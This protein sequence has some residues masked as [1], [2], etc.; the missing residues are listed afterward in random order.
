[1]ELTPSG[2]IGNP[3]GG[4][5][6]FMAQYSFA[7]DVL[8]DHRESVLNYRVNSQSSPC[9]IY[10]FSEGDIDILRTDQLTERGIN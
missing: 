3:T 1:M 8:P 4:G 10:S 7:F 6:F 5:Q 9:V 2:Q